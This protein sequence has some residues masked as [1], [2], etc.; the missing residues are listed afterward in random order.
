MPCLFR[1]IGANQTTDERTPWQSLTAEGV[2]N[3]SNRILL[4]LF[5]SGVPF[6]DIKETKKELMKYTALS[7]PDRGKLKALIIQALA[8][9]KQEFADGV[10]EDADRAIHYDTCRHLLVGGN[11]CEY[12]DPKTG[13]MTSYPLEE[14]MT[15]RDRTGNLFEWIIQTPLAYQTLPEDVKKLVNQGGYGP[16]D[17]DKPGDGKVSDPDQWAAIRNPIWSP[18]NVYTHGELVGDTWLVH[19][20]AWGEIVP[21]S[22][23]KYPKD[24]LPWNFIRFIALKGEPYGRSYCEDYEGDIQ[25]YDA[26]NQVI[27]EGGAVM[28]KLIYLVKPGS[29]VNKKAFSEAANG[30]VLTG[31]VE[32]IGTV[33]ADKQADLT[34]VANQIDRIEKRLERIF[35]MNQAATRDAERVTAEEVKFMIKQLEGTLGG[36]YSNLV[37]GWQRPY[38][39]QKIKA[40]QKRGDMTALP[41]GTTK[42]TILTGDAAFARADQGDDLMEFVKDAVEIL[43]PPVAEKYIKIGNLLSRVASARVIDTDGLLMSDD[44]VQQQEQQEQMQALKEK[45]APAAV[46]ALGGMAQNSQQAALASQQQPPPQGNTPQAPTTQGGPST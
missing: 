18:I 46:T 22:Q 32:E 36:V 35:I 20:E 9:V 13:K 11:H 29:S 8:K 16:N 6:I 3:L 30:A 1:E 17:A 27:T 12:T 33:K 38:A 14:F 41:K 40:L 5:P 31:D 34:I 19:D 25:T 39:V 28:A 2:N 45:A 37:V 15:W 4:A 24:E 7:P 10:S 42:V 44:E 23:Q 43:T 26:V 21:G